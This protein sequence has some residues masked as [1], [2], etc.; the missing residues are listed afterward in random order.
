MEPQQGDA[1]SPRCEQVD[2]VSRSSGSTAP[3]NTAVFFA[4]V[5]PKVSFEHLQ[6]LFSQYGEVK[7]LKLFKRWPTARTSKGCGTVRFATPQAAAAALA[8]LNLVHTFPGYDG[9]DEDEPMVVEWLNPS[10]QAN[11]KDTA[12]DRPGRL[13]ATGIIALAGVDARSWHAELH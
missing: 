2:T 12:Y 8:A 6:Q 11:D 10:R 5:H 4:R 13:G 9:F 7:E 1:C 3:Q